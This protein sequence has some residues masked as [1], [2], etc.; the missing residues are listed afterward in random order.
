MRMTSTERSP[1]NEGRNVIPY[2]DR[3]MF[4]KGNSVNNFK[5]GNS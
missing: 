5:K 1:T 3:E 4:R 2:L